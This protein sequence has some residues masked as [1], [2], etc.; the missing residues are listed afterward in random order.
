VVV[1]AHG[2]RDV[3]DGGVTA[4]RIS[5]SAMPT[6]TAPASVVAG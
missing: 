4:D 3:V 5:L 6:S 1:H 2:V